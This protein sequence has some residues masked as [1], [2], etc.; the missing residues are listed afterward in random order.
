MKVA[1]LFL[2]LSFSPFTN[3]EPDRTVRA[4]LCQSWK[5]NFGA[6]SYTCD[7]TTRYY[8][9]VTAQEVNRVLH[10]LNEEITS[11]K[12]RITELEDNA[13]ENSSNLP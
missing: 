10:V 13:Q 1:L 8:D 2:I 5:Y 7:F 12:A 6:S 11:L 4:Q 3:A 9:L